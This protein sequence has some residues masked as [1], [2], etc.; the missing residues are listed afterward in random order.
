MVIVKRPLDPMYC[1]LFVFTH[2]YHRM[3]NSYLE[4]SFINHKRMCRNSRSNDIHM[5]GMSSPKFRRILF[6]SYVR[7]LFTWLYSIF[8][9]M[10]DCQRDDLSHFYITCLKRTLGYW[11][12]SE[13]MFVALTG[14]K[15]LENHCHSYWNKYREYLNKSTD[16][17]LLYEQ[18]NLNL[19]RSF[20]LG[21]EMSIPRLYRSKR[22]VPFSS[23]IR[24]CL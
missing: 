13:T 12:W 6:D 19:F 14:G 24:R 3:S 22:F 10:A 17:F 2:K 1:V 20:W 5:Y 7:P 15:S 18:T 21:K 16:G 9:L 11:Y 4:H 23:T 8:P